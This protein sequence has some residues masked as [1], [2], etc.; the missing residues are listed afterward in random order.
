VVGTQTFGKGIV[1][2]LL[3]LGDGTAIKLTTAH[4]YTPGGTDL[5][6]VGLTPDIEVELDEELRT[7]AVVEKSEDNQLQAAIE[8]LQ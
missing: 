5:H 6:G 4:Y 8:A 2:S 3:P 1:Q 7:Q